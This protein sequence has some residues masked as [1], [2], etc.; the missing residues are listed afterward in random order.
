MGKTLFVEA[1]RV[2]HLKL[3]HGGTYWQI[4]IVS[5]ISPVLTDDTSRI[6]LV[7]DRNAGLQSIRLLFQPPS[8]VTD[9]TVLG[10]ESALTVNSP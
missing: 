6:D 10:Y 8:P 5:T 4:L 1:D 9:D 3:F 7:T 2:I